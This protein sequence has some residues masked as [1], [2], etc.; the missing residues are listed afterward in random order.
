MSKTNPKN[1][2]IRLGVGDLIVNTDSQAVGI[3]LEK[4]RLIKPSSESTGS[5]WEWAWSI[6]W[7]KAVHNASIKYSN[8]IKSYA[9]TEESIINEIREGQVE[10]YSV[11]Q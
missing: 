4:H 2:S 1:Q 9:C 11:K 3:L 5:S 6:K 8:W 10:H 7:S